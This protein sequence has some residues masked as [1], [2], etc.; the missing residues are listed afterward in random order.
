[1]RPLFTVHAGEYLVGNH[2]ENKYPGDLA[3]L[4]ARDASL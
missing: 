1:M 2:I 4:M 3:K